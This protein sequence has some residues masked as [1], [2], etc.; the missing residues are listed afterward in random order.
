MGILEKEVAV[1]LNG[2]NQKRYE[3]LGYEIPRY[4]DSRGKTSI[5]RGTEILVRVEDLSEKSKVKLNVC[6]DECGEFARTVSY[7][8][9]TRSR[10][11]TDGIDR[12]RSCSSKRTQAI[13]N[14]KIDYKN[15][16]EYFAKSN[17][18]EY[19]LEE[20]DENNTLKPDEIGFSS[21][22]RF[23]WKCRKC[24]SKFEGKAGNR[25]IS[26]CNCPYCSGSKV[27]ET[28]SLWTTDPQVAEMLLNRELG[29]EVTRGS[30]KK[31]EFK[32]PT[33]DSVYK[34][35]VKNVVNL[36]IGCL[37]CS[38]GFSYPEKI[39][40]SLL[41]QLNIKYETQK[42]FEWSE[43][44]RYDFY[45]PSYNCIIETHGNQHY[46]NSYYRFKRYLKDELSNDE[47]KENNAKNNGII[48][49]IVIN[50][51]KSNLDYIKSNCLSSKLN[52][53]FNL[54]MVNWKEC[55]R[56]ASETLIKETCAIWNNTNLPTSKIAEEL[57][58]SPTTVLR[59]LKKGAE[60][61]ICDYTKESSIGRSKE[62][63]GKTLRK[64]VVQLSLNGKLLRKWIS[65]N[66]ASR[67]TG[68]FH[69]SIGM[70]CKGKL[71]KSGGF[72]WMYEEDY[73]KLL[74]EEDHNAG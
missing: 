23:L 43:N 36:G 38:D 8:E 22:Q 24:G 11:R 50:C 48:N 66:E 3:E 64:P 14:Q 39:M 61:G 42:S 20:F 72:K 59:Y 54:N 73:E 28:N 67:E 33:C 34:K 5:K 57:S 30:G 4:K 69:T 45:I 13:S 47:L 52:K 58:I 60:I 27:N 71:Q 17:N 2:A 19:L 12:C 51:S 16:L 53:I 49:Y 70:T 10:N 41:N 15:T 31:V 6:C 65:I 21:N 40:I 9:I 32:C 56:Y 68:I 74:K 29:N 63:M 62:N 44:K 25:T 7:A 1:I 26:N 37:I 55:E 46:K 18:K 35:F